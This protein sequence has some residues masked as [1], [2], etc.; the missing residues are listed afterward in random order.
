MLKG[1]SKINRSLCPLCI[2]ANKCNMEMEKETGI[3]Q[4]VCWCV[5]MNFSADLLA[6]VPAPAQGQACICAAC[7]ASFEGNLRSKALS[8]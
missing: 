6:A 7:A 2:K 4:G 5:E 1:P 3:N 8:G